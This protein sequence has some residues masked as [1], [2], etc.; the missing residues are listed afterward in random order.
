MALPW[1]HPKTKVYYARLWVPV[2]LKPVLKKE[3]VRRSLRTKDLQEAKRRYL[4]VASEIVAEW[5][6]IRSAA[7]FVDEPDEAM[8]SARRISEKEAHALAG[9]FYRAVVRQH[10]E[11]PGSPDTWE[12]ALLGIQRSLPA[13]ERQAGITVI[14]MGPWSVGANNAARVMGTEVR[15]FLDE[16]DDN[17]DAPSFV[18]LCGAV[19][20]AKRD[21][22]EHLLRNARGNFDADPKANRFPPIS[23][24]TAEADPT[25]EGPAYGYVEVSDAWYAAGGIAAKT[26]KSWVGKL[27]MLT[28]FLGKD[29]LGSITQ[30]DV[31]LWRDHRQAQGISPRTISYADM[32]G[33]RAIFNWAIKSKKFPRI[34]V[35]P[36]A[37]M[38]VKVPK[39]K[40]TRQKGFT[41]KEAHKILAATL[42]P[43]SNRYGETGA[44]AR[45]WGPWLAAYSGARIGEIMQ[46]HADNVYAEEAS[47]GRK[48]MCVRLTPE[49]GD[50][51][52]G[53][54]RIVPLHPHVIEQGFLAY[55]KR[56]RGKP[57]F[58][59]PSASRKADAANTQA[60]KAGQRIASWV[61]GLGI[62]G[63]A[64]NHGW[65]HR[66]KTISR[67]CGIDRDVGNFL[68][69]HSAQD[70]A[71]EYGDYLIEVLHENVC[72]LP[73]YVIQRAE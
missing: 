60:D 53:E 36:F 57:L 61:R 13:R 38:A 62:A 30:D 20:L 69:G 34:V 25:P 2:D 24:R 47:D 28:E 42:E 19:A 71:A 3:E 58:Y 66:L 54:F 73:R 11:N 52:T 14:E 8:P 72:K 22:F 40:T 1:L 68:T 17:L 21:A 23:P 9:E 49:D 67:S 5:E 59:E 31:M 51:K 56:R 16:R 10:E 6:Q 45:R 64:P 26:R 15:A 4:H 55:V 63:V 44:G 65:R 39:T 7:D 46:L 12:K 29:D 50:M 43:P 35:N 32:A 27:R 70:V 37:E 18:R 48:I 41:L 33:P